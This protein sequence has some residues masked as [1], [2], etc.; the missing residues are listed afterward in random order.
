[1][2][3]THAV[4]FLS[5]MR[6]KKHHCLRIK[7]D[8]TDEVENLKSAVCTDYSIIVREFAS[9]AN[10]C[11]FSLVEGIGAEQDGRAKQRAVWERNRMTAV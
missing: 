11:F 5:C 8:V 7:Q 1:M 10:V 4:Y 2:L 6:K 9:S 3:S